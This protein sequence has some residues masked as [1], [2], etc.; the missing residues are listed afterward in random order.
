MPDCVTGERCEEEEENI[1]IARHKEEK[2]TGKEE[3]GMLVLPLFQ[4]GEDDNDKEEEYDILD[5]VK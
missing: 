5:R 3:E 2:E 1:E 4:K